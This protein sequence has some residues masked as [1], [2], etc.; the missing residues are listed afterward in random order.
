MNEPNIE[1]ELQD[2][3]ARAIIRAY[4]SAEKD[5]LEEPVYQTLEKKYPSLKDM[6][7]SARIKTDP[8]AA[9][10]GMKMM[11]KITRVGSKAVDIVNILIDDKE[12]KEPNKV[13]TGVNDFRRVFEEY[14]PH[15]EQF[16]A[17]ISQAV[18]KVSRERGLGI[19]ATVKMD[20]HRDD[21]YR[22]VIPAR[23]VAE[24]FMEQSHD[25]E[26][27]LLDSGHHLVDMVKKIDTDI[28]VESA[29][30]LPTPKA[31]EAYFQA[32]RDFRMSEFDR[33]YVNR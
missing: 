13:W 30:T 15:R 8:I 18:K 11:F 27:Q 20:A 10:K 31:T 22:M 21:V 29:P 16:Y 17:G 3:T 4:V 14:T 23:S 9:I 5:R 6:I 26:K 12:E 33:I 24:A 32:V 1:A 28:K 7:A 2:P 25:F 19:D